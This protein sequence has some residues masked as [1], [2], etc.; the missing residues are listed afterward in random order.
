MYIHVR[1]VCDIHKNT[2]L[3]LWLCN[4][5]SRYNILTKRNAFIKRKHTRISLEALLGPQ[6]RISP[7][8]CQEQNGEVNYFYAT[9]R[10]IHSSTDKYH[11]D[12]MLTKRNREN[13]YILNDHI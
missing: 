5:V 11:I 4:S 1:D 8:A 9:M 12:L 10:Y 13:V 6:A 3:I 7:N 2:H